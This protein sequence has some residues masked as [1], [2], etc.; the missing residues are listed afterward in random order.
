MAIDTTTTMA[1]ELLAEIL[2]KKSGEAKPEA[3]EEDAPDLDK[4]SKKAPPR[5]GICRRCGEDKP[6]NRLMLCYVCW[7]KSNLEENG[8]REGLPHPSSCE[9]EVPGGHA[10]RRSAGN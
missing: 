10:E 5:E 3:A 7:V 2:E 6:I 4:L 1:D 9:C 8:W